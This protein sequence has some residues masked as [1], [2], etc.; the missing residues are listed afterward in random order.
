M[1]PFVGRDQE[2]ALLLDRWRDA[3]KGKGQVVLLSGEAGIGKSRNTDRRYASA[4]GASAPVVLRYQCSP[5]HINDAFHPIIG[6]ISAG[7]RPPS[8]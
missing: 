8:R 3:T 5:H 6:Q 7:G 4:L 2:V 1:T